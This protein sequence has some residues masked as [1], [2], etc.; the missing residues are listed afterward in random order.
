MATPQIANNDITEMND[1]LR[2]ANKYLSATN[3]SNRMD[4]FLGGYALPNLRSE[5]REE[6]NLSD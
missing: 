1:C 2:S 4:S 3:V 5:Q 6:D